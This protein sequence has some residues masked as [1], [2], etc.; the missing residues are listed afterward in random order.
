MEMLDNGILI[1]I[2]GLLKMELAMRCKVI[3]TQYT[4]ECLF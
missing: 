1:G 4:F 3:N 2:K